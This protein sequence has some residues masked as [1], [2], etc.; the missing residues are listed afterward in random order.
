LRILTE[1][2]TMAFD[3]FKLTSGPIKAASHMLLDKVEIVFIPVTKQALGFVTVI[4]ISRTG[5][6]IGKKHYWGF[7]PEN[8][9][10]QDVI[11]IAQYGG[12][13]ENHGLESAFTH[14]FNK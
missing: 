9:T 11:N 14:H 4:D 13:F 10:D 2:L 5:K 3:S 8:P 7:L 6:H 12:K 1:E